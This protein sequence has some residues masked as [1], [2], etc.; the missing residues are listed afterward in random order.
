MCS[1]CSVPSEF[2]ISRIRA[3]TT[4]PQN[5]AACRSLNDLR[6]D[7]CILHAGCTARFERTM[8][9]GVARSRMADRH[10][11]HRDQVFRSRAVPPTRWRPLHRTRLARNYRG[12]HAA[13]PAA[14]RGVVPCWRCALHGRSCAICKRNTPSKPRVVRLPRGLA[15]V[16]R[17]SW[18]VDV[19]WQLHTCESRVTAHDIAW[20]PSH[21]VV[22]DSHTAPFNIRPRRTTPVWAMPSPIGSVQTAMAI[23]LAPRDHRD[24]NCCN[25]S[26]K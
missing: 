20:S 21:V 24:T 14:R 8:A 6:I 4:R 22:R 1:S 26:S 23:P 11:R 2:D 13:P 25:R 16:R 3:R 17:G 19:C 9:M 15:Y 7:R 18:G 12:P 10:L 5:H